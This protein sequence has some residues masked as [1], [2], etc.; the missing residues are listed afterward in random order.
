M[1]FYVYID[2]ESYKTTPTLNL[3]LTNVGLK[4]PIL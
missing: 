2:Q 4:S 3:S 1:C